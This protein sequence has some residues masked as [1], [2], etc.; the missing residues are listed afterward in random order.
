MVQYLEVKDGICHY[1]PR[2][3]IT[4]AD[5]VE[6]IGRAIAFC[7]NRRIAKLFVDGTRLTGIPIPTLVDRF[8]MVEEW[9]HAAGSVVAIALVVEARYIHPQKFGVK[10]AADLGLMSDVFTSDAEALAW[11]ENPAAN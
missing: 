3:E 2:G 9:A 6:L 1:R 8:L 7:R 4:L 5:V 10:V 11:L